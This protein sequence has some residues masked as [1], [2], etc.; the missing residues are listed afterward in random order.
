MRYH[1]DR[2][3]GVTKVV[4]G[5]LYAVDDVEPAAVTHPMGRL[6]FQL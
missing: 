1:V 5:L 6:E 4:D 2:V 3:D